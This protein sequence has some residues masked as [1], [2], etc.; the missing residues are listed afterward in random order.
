MKSY[1]RQRRALDN[2]RLEELIAAADDKT[3]ASEHQT[4]QLGQRLR[5]VTE[6]HE[7]SMAEVAA[8]LE[9]LEASSSPQYARLRCGS[10]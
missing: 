4:I 1:E 10:P 2:R 5:Q 9:E 8:E 3:R 6:T 7:V